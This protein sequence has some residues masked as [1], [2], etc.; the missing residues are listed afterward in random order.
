MAQTIDVQITFN[1]KSPILIGDKHT[2]LS[3][4]ANLVRALD[5]GSQVGPAGTN[6]LQVQTSVVAAHGT[7]TAASVQS[8]D[9]V[10]IGGVA[11]TATQLRAKGTLTAATAIAGTTCVINGVTFTGVTGAA[12]PGAATFSVDTSNTACAT[13]L[14]AQVNAFPSS[15]LT[16]LVGAISSGA[17]VT[18]YA[19]ALGTSGN[20]IP[21]VGTAT[22]LVASGAHLAGGAAPTNNQFDFV[23]TDTHVG[24]DIVRAVKA[25]TS[26][27]IQAVSAHSVTGVV[28]LTS[29][30]GG[31]AGN[32]ITLT[33]SNGGRLAVSGANLA[34]GAASAVTRWFF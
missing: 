25:S 15:K 33:S 11:L 26:A 2:T 1:G 28:T 10:T 6:M 19:R 29:L 7:V 9:T 22:V 3:G 30:V 13:S 16:G 4:L 18:V 17:V 21:L 32:T 23:G 20:S 34:S 24:D 14:A 27:A 8:A 31:L 5:H 12:T